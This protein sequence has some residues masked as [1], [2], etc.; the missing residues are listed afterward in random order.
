MFAKMC[1]RIE[2]VKEKDTP[3]DIHLHGMWGKVC[4]YEWQVETKHMF[5]AMLAQAL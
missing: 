2:C 5:K 3:L 1:I 4:Q